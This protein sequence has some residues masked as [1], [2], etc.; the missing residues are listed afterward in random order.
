MMKF[1][2]R[3]QKTF[4]WIILAGFVVATFAYFG[5][6]GLLPAS[7]QHAARVRK[8]KIPMRHFEAV[9]SQQIEQLRRSGAVNIS[10]ETV[11]QIRQKVLVDLVS[12]EAFYQQARDCGFSTSDDELLFTLANVPQ[13]QKEGKF[14]PEEYQIQLRYN[15][16]MSPREFE[17]TQ[18]RQLT[19]F[20]MR[21]LILTAAKITEE[22][23]FLE[24]IRR[25]PKKKN[26]GWPKEKAPFTQTLLQ[27]RQNLIYNEWV[28][29]LN[30]KF[31][32][33]IEV[34]LRE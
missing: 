19:I 4:I 15:L 21:N 7:S 17:E 8:A 2:H 14:S 13:F 11:K 9:L 34:Y 23:T 29:T 10:P 12:E 25:N 1:F 3:H 6:A 30:E 31:G 28:K 32:P 18:R 5:G 22:E 16:K 24:Y 20:K 33:E 27:E 26:K